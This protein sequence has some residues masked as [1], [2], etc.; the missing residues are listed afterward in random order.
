MAARFLMWPVG[1][2]IQSEMGSYANNET[3]NFVLK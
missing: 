2:S 3:T 1:W